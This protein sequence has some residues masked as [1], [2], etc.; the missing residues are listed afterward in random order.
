MVL[1]IVGFTII[2]SWFLGFYILVIVIWTFISIPAF[3]PLKP[4]V[5]V[6]LLCC[7]KVCSISQVQFGNSPVYKLDRKLGKGGFGQVYVGRRVTGGAGRS[8]PNAFEVFLTVSVPKKLILMLITAF[9]FLFAGCFK[10]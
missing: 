2:V 6:L 5:E 9:G 1:L 8:G 10:I 4:V 3:N 7:L